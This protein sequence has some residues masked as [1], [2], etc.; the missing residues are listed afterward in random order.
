MDAGLRQ[1]DELERGGADPRRVAIGHM[2]CLNDPQAEV[3]TAIARRGAWVAFDRA[4]TLEQFVPDE[5]RVRMA[6]RLIERG[7]ARQLLL[8]SDFTG[9]RSL[10]GPLYGRTKTVFA[11]KLVAA[12][13]AE[14]VVRA[15]LYDNPRR[16]LAFVPHS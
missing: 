7:F 14:A 1:L 13:V 3:I 8:S 15:I 11:P 16:F 10:E 6:A 12:G 5:V 2:C 9:A 4:N